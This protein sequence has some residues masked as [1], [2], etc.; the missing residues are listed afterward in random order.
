MIL[1]KKVPETRGRPRKTNKLTFNVSAKLPSDLGRQLTAY[2]NGVRPATSVS[3]VVSL[4]IEQYLASVGY[5]PPPADA[6]AD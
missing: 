2:A 4:A 6:D 1:M 5:W 3:S